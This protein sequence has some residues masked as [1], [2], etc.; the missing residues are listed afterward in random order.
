MPTQASNPRQAKQLLT[1]IQLEQLNQ[2]HRSVVCACTKAKSAP[3]R[4][5]LH[6]LIVHAAAKFCTLEV[7][8]IKL[9]CGGRGVR[10]GVAH[11]AAAPPAGAGGAPAKG[12]CEE[13]RGV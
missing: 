2:S 8:Q 9:S 10:G 13:G 12:G 4:A 3:G 5:A 6:A 1:L 7:S 11:A